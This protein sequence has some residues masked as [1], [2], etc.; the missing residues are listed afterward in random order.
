MQQENGALHRKARLLQRLLG[1]RGFAA[2]RGGK[3][4]EHA[5]VTDHSGQLAQEVGHLAPRGLQQSV[6]LVHL[7]HTGAVAVQQVLEARLAALVAAQGLEGCL[8]V[9]HLRLRHIQVGVQSVAQAPPNVIQ[10]QQRLAGAALP[11]L[12]RLVHL[13]AVPAVHA[14]G[15]LLPSEALLQLPHLVVDLPPHHLAR[16][17]TN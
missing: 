12:G 10:S 16:E 9:L 17:T 1:Q 8:E 15:P 11:T 3:G 14:Q 4:V 7:G 6:A 2:F 13:R 5:T